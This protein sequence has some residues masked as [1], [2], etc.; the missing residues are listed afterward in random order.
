VISFLGT[1]CSIKLELKDI[2][3]TSVVGTRIQL[4]V[5]P[6]TSAEDWPFILHDKHE[7]VVRTTRQY[8]PRVIRFDLALSETL[9][10][11]MGVSGR[12]APFFHL[13]LI[14]KGVEEC[15][16]RNDD[17][18]NILDKTYWIGKDLSHAQDERDFYE[19]ILQ[20]KNLETS[21]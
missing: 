1:K 9:V 7:Q 19:T 16:T 8:R 14:E 12:T 11:R 10:D 3:N 18:G 5:K 21:I 17:N 20:T 6:T 13:V 15:R 4:T 2:G